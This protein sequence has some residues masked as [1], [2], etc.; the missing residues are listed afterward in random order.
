MPNTGRFAAVIAALTAA[1]LFFA[2]SPVLA[3]DRISG[4]DI[5]LDEDYDD[6]VYLMG[7]NVIINSTIDGDLLVLAQTLVLNGE[8]TGDLLFAGQALTI[9]GPVG[10]DLRAGGMIVIVEDGATITDDVNAGTYSFEMRTGSSVGGDVYFGAGQVILHDVGGSVFGGSSAVHLTGTIEGDVQVGVSSGED[11]LMMAPMMMEDPNMP[12]IAQVSPG[13]SFTQNAEIQGDLLYDS[14]Q[15][16]EI[17][18]GA[19]AGSVSR[20]TAS[21]MQGTDS[22]QPTRAPVPPIVRFVGTVI[23]SFIVLMVVGMMLQRFAPQF[24]AGVR[25]TLRTKM[26]ASFGAGFLAYVVFYVLLPIL[27]VLFI[28]FIFLPLAGTGD[29]L[30]ELLG[31]VGIGGFAAFNFVTGWIAPIIV[32]LLIGGMIFRGRDGAPLNAAVPLAVG[33][34]ILVIALAIPF[35]GSFLLAMLIGMVGLG[36][37]LL[38]LRARGR[39][40][41]AFDPEKT[42][43]ERAGPMADKATV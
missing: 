18:D 15:A 25:E 34:V 36:A 26:L 5:T 24:V 43:I 14:Q 13:L 11:G 35:V 19:V 23:G 6:D 10:D 12:E 27:I 21:S 41:S 3:S 16:A 20:Q 8:V 33:L 37:M 29:R 38:Y 4:G 30:R 2:V 7:E 22:E 39:D 1:V 32:A 40:E 31:L 28:A 9:N 42:H 17:P